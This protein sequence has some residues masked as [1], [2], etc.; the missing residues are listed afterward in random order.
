MADFEKLSGLTGVTQ[1]AKD[2]SRARLAV[3][4]LT[5]DADECRR[6]LDI[7][8]LWPTQDAKH[9]PATVLSTGQISNSPK[10][11]TTKRNERRMAGRA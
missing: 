5:D 10:L 8:D 4:E 1:Q 6:L 11:A 2:R 7:L 3:A 9:V